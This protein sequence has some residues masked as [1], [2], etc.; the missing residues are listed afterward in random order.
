[1]PHSDTGNGTGNTAMLDVQVTG[2]DTPQRDPDNGIPRILQC[3]SGFLTKSKFSLFD[4]CIGKHALTSTLLSI[5]SL[6]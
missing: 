1:M 4:I 5:L 6:I 2:A 3:G